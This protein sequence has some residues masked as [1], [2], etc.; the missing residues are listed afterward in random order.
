MRPK[1]AVLGQCFFKK[2][3]SLWQTLQMNNYFLSYQLIKIEQVTRAEFK[4]RE[5]RSLKQEKKKIAMLEA[6]EAQTR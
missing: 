4:G 3:T 6:C 2:A 1:A 5:M